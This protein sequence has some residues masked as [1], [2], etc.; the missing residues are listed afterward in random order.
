MI[1]FHWQ[2][3]RALY[4]QLEISRTRLE[5]NSYIWQWCRHSPVRW[6]R[7]GPRV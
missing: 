6:Q 3:D 5:Y 1:S 7:S 4:N 2:F